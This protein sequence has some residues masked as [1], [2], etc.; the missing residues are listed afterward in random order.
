M[1]DVKISPASI[2][3]A[4][5]MILIL[6]AFSWLTFSPK[7]APPPPAVL[8][9]EAKAYLASLDIGNV[10]VQEAGNMVNQ[11][12]IEILGDISN[13]GNRVVRLAEVTCRLPGITA[14][15]K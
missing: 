8:T 4:L 12:V 11:R 10:R 15:R 7:P 13:K 9:A 3:I 2:V 1:P 5:A 6:G 14:G